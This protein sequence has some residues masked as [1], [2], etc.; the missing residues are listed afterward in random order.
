MGT[1]KT[2]VVTHKITPHADDPKCCAAECEYLRPL[3]GHDCDRCRLFRVDLGRTRLDDTTITW[4]LRCEP[5]LEA[6]ASNA[7]DVPVERPGDALARLVGECEQD[8]LNAELSGLETGWEHPATRTS[9]RKVVAAAKAYRA[10]KGGKRN[11]DP[12]PTG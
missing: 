3:R 7:H 9:W 8:R 12:N 2:I 5:C 4:G 11:G 1:G 6:S 10:P